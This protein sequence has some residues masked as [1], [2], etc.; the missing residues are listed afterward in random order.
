M[1]NT[2]GAVKEAD[3]KIQGLMGGWVQSCPLP[4]ITSLP[5]I[6]GRLKG[7]SLQASTPKR[8]TTLATWG[9]VEHTCTCAAVSVSAEADLSCSG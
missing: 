4:P 8:A 6:I 1:A 7:L 9:D 5:L 3:D 2:D